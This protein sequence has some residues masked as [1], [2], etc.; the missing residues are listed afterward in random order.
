MTTAE[1][2]EAI[3]AIGNFISQTFD[4]L[5]EEQNDACIAQAVQL[6]AEL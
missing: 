4:F 1:K 6:I 3:K 2:I 5:T